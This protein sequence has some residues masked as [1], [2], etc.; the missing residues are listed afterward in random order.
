MAS[1]LVVLGLDR[2]DRLDRLM[3]MIVFCS[4]LVLNED[5][6]LSHQLF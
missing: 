1:L 6:G 3:V 2:L 4:L 5:S